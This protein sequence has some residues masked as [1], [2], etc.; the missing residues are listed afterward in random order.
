MV[1][2]RGPSHPAVSLKTYL[3]IKFYLH[4]QQGNVANLKFQNR[5]SRQLQYI[6][7]TAHWFAMTSSQAYAFPTLYTPGGISLM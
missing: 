4:D 1:I 6:A 2:M 3:T 7:P 5:F